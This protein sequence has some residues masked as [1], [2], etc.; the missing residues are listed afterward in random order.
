[1][2]VLFLGLVS[3]VMSHWGNEMTTYIHICIY[4][5]VYVDLRVYMDMVVAGVCFSLGRARNPNGSSHVIYMCA[6]P[7]LKTKRS[8]V[9]RDHGGDV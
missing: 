7:S 1:M 3:V 6:I 4:M 2:Q 9:S 5:N 8:L